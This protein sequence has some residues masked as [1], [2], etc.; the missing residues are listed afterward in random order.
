MNV[1]LLPYPKT[2]IVTFGQ[3][4]SALDVVHLILV[5]LWM[6]SLMLLRLLKVFAVK[7]QELHTSVS[8]DA[9]LL[10]ASPAS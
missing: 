1:L 8:Y 2:E 4:L 6:G 10:I 5:V 7:Y 9:D 3:R